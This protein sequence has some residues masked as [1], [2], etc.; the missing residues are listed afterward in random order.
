MKFGR[1]RTAYRKLL[2]EA[3]AQEPVSLFG[4]CLTSNH[5]HLLLHSE[6]DAG[7]SRLMKTVAGQFA[8]NYNRRKNRSGAY[9]GDRYHAT[10]I[11][12]QQYLLN[13]LCYIDLNMVRAGVVP[14]P[15]EW[16]WCSYR[17]LTG[18]RKRYC[19]VDVEAL[20]QAIGDGA[21]RESLAENYVQMIQDRIERDD[22]K[23]DASWSE[24]LA[25]GSPT[26]VK[27]VAATL[28]N[29]IRTETHETQS[30]ALCLRES[31]A[32]YG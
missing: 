26:F 29:R 15:K 8:Q 18:Q 24:S 27:R 31:P 22:L 16:D 1:D 28:K 19:L 7:M 20:S 25:V 17:E 30:G 12:G 13:C 2:A 14:H 32:N 10:Q 9:W 23:R 11:D 21:S 4:Y 3:L 6:S 5:L